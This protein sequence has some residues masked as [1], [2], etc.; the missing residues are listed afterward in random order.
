MPA[1]VA[2]AV[3]FVAVAALVIVAVARAH[4]AEQVLGDIEERFGLRRDDVP[5]RKLR[6]LSREDLLRPRTLGDYRGEVDALVARAAELGDFG[7]DPRLRRACA[8]A[9]EG[10]KRLRPAILLE[11][12]RAAQA[13]HPPPC[14]IDTAEMALAV[15]YLHAA[16]LVVDDLP[17]FDDDSVR[18]GRPAVHAA[19]G[20]AVA[21]LAALTLLASA[22]GGVARQVEWIRRACPAFVGA[23]RIGS[24]L[25]A[26]AT[27]AVGGSGAAVGQLLDS[28]GPA[29]GEPAVPPAEIARLKTAS[30]FEL[31]FYA[32]W[33]AAGAPAASADDLRRAGR[34][35][36]TAFQIADDL[37]DMAQDAARKA[38]GKPGVNFAN[39]YGAGEARRLVAQHLNACALILREKNIATPVWAE[40]YEKVWD[41]AEPPAV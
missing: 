9:L 19:E 24:R 15:E 28:V 2:L 17:A 31:A 21:Q 7:P 3:A 33:L 6:A 41:M 35:F 10:G 11:V 12:C 1:P 36:G 23:D 5:P 29:A 34:H 20:A 40:I 13:A 27:R 26:E 32:G 22:F 25:Y 4:R 38:G 16:S 39:E 37:G 18:R 30:F 8:R 14:T